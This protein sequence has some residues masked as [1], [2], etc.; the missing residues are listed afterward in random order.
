MGAAINGKS[1]GETT[2]YVAPNGKT[3]QVKVLAAKP[4]QA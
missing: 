1:V 4:Y 3:I 2:S